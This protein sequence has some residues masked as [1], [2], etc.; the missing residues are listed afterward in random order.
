M[1]A[2]SLVGKIKVEIL[3]VD[4]TKLQ[5]FEQPNVFNNKY[6]THGVLENN[7]YYENRKSGE[8]VVP[9]DWNIIISYNPSIY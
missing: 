4:D 5:I 9:T 3:T 1:A 2:P 7:K 6:G 8:H